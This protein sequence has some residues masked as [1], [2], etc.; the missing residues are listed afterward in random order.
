MDLSMYQDKLTPEERLQIWKD[1]QDSPGW[2]VLK[3][4]FLKEQASIPEIKDCDSEKAFI[5]QQTKF[6]G[7]AEF[8][9]KPQELIRLITVG[10]N[11]A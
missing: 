5:Y 11:R 9:N 8:F 6:K 4:M 1:L 10:M 2:L 3:Q 7:K